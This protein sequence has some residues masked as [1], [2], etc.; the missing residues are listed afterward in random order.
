M[1]TVHTGE[2]FPETIEKSIFL[3]GPTPRSKDAPSWRVPE[4]LG[5]LKDL[6]YDGYVFIP[7]FKEAGR[8]CE[9]DY[10]NQIDWETEGLNLADLIVAWVPR[11]LKTMPAF[12]TN[13]ECGEW[14]KSGKMIFGAPVD[15][16][17]NKYLELKADENFVP[18]F[19]T[20]EETLKRAVLTLG[21]GAER[22]GGERYVPL[23]IWKTESFQNW[24]KNLKS[25]GN[26]LDGAKV[27]WSWRTGPNKTFL[28]SW[29]MHVK[30]WVA[31]EKRY[32]SNEFVISRTDI[33]SAF[34]WRKYNYDLMQSEVVLVKEFRSPARTPDGFVHELPGGS[35]FK[36]GMKPE[37][38]VAE[39]I[40]EETGL[41][42][43]PLRFKYR[44]SRQIA[45]T[46]STHHSH[47]YSVSL[48]EQEINY[49]KTAAKE[50]KTFGNTKDDSELTYLEVKTLKQVIEEKL[51]DWATLGMIWQVIA[52][53][54]SPLL[55]PT[56]LAS[57]SYSPMWGE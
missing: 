23:Q 16:P 40:K 28:F 10:H 12:T 17:K 53:K 35:T 5:I 3:V 9:F 18:R 49:Y 41:S 11:D 26:R 14:I 32:K 20:L 36:A 56:L 52:G 39:E 19:S 25:A 55:A 2:K 43:H 8:E 37:E 47:L 46:W 1:R 21:A 42:L 6:G 30:V 57:H 34:L 7:E 4:A 38:V 31:S 22:V 50:S 44:G 54:D 24:Y 45:G 27:L 13:F 29:I 15:A 51:V 33:S 48:S